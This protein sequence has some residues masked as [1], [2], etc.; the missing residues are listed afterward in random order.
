MLKLGVNIDHIATV[1]QARKAA[2][3]A[4]RSKAPSSRRRP[5]PGASPRTCARTAAIS[6]TPTSA[7]SPP[8]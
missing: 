5:E 8:M 2:A 4:G 1:R 6:R 3:P 7:N